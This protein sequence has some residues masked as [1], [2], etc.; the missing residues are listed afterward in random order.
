MQ[1]GPNGEVTVLLQ[2]MRSGDSGAAD[3]LIPLVV[4]ELRRLARL[5]LRNERPGHTLQPTALVNEA[6][7]R[8]VGDQARDWQNRAHFIGVSVSVM[9]RILIDHARRKR[10]LKR[11]FEDQVDVEDYAGLSYEQADELMALNIALDQLEKM[12]SRQRQVVELRYF[13]GLSTEETAEVLKV[14][15]ITVKRDWVVARAWLKGQL[16]P[17]GSAS[18]FA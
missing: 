18:S 4:D 9:R 15:P 17:E 16:R 5:Q 6:Y 8:L 12:S 2:Q 11:G 14:S 13:G 1:A 7:L 3:K 10:A